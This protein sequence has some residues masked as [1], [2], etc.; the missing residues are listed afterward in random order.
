MIT[1]GSRHPSVIMHVVNALTSQNAVI[2][3]FVNA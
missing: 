1:T 2:M 3:Q